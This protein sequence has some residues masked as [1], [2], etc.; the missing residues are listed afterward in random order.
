LLLEP[1]PQHGAV[2]PIYVPTELHNRVIPRFAHRQRDR[3]PPI[4]AAFPERVDYTSLNTD[5]L[6]CNPDEGQRPPSQSSAN[7]QRRLAER[8][9]A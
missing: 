3:P 5:R 4:A 2:A 8:R 6:A 9:S 7:R 1:R